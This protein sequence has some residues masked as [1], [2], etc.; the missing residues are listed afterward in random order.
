MKAYFSLVCLALL[1]VASASAQYAQMA[2]LLHSGE[3][4]NFFTS[5]ALRQA[6]EAAVDGDVISLSSGTFE[7][8]SIHKN[9]SIRGA[10]IKVDGISSNT[11][12]S[13]VTAKYSIYID[14]PNVDKCALNLEGITF[15]VS[16]NVLNANIVNAQKCEFKEINS[17]YN[18]KWSAGTFF[19]CLFKRFDDDNLEK[20]SLEFVNCIFSTDPKAHYLN[21]RYSDFGNN[22]VAKQFTNCTILCCSSFSKS[23]LQ[24][25]V[26]DLIQ[27]SN[28][29]TGI[30]SNSSAY[31]C[32]V[33]N[34]HR[35]ECSGS[36]NRTLGGA[37]NLFAETGFYTL[38]PEFD[39]FL[40]NDNTQVGAWGGTFPFNTDVS[41]PKITR[42][43]VSK[44]TTTDGKLSIDIEVSTEK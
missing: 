38:L 23:M 24:N 14:C 41:N 37:E 42:F 25:C 5:S 28:T 18:P 10:G 7:I 39:S 1:S 32:I 33:R 15:P 29:Y 35:F 2:T 30:S 27:G 21:D 19:N 31:N 8:D 26:V 16:I 36:D 6:L 22:N 20:G 11:T 12:P 40:G 4:T 3:L 43:D 34:V 13:V 9:V 17:N 44:Q